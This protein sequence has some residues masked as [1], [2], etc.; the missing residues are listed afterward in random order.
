MLR[1]TKL[2]YTIISKINFFEK[3][4]LQNQKNSECR[5]E[6]LGDDVLT[7]FAKLMMAYMIRAQD[8]EEIKERTHDPKQDAEIARPGLPLEV[9]F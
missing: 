7:D 3:I 2:L 8:V 4:S 1:H 9:L 5:Q 6:L